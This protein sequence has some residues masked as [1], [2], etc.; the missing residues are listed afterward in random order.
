[1]RAPAWHHENVGVALRAAVLPREPTAYPGEPPHELVPV[2]VGGASCPPDGL[3][4]IEQAHGHSPFGSCVRRWSRM[5]VAG[6]DGSTRPQYLQYQK[7]PQKKVRC[8]MV[9]LL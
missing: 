1:M 5:L 7:P 8:G 9:I 3:L 6:S 2:G 4:V